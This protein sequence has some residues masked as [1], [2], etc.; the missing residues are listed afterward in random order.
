MSVPS[1]GE[2]SERGL[3]R[4]RKEELRENS[5]SRELELEEEEPKTMARQGNPIIHKLQGNHGNQ[6][7]R[8]IRDSTS[9]RK[10]GDFS[11]IWRQLINASNFEVKLITMIMLNYY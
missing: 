6:K 2:I 4:L 1:Q 11:C 8:T 3:R 9:P 10:V 7:L 5:I